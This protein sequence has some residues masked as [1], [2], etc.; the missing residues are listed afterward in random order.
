MDAQI[1][2][3]YENYPRPEEV[4]REAIGSGW[5]DPPSLAPITRSS[6]GREPYP[7]SPPQGSRR[8]LLA[9]V[10]GIGVVAVVGYGMFNSGASGGQS[11]GESGPDPWD[12]D[13]PGG[14]VLAIGGDVA[15]PE[16]WTAET[17]TDTEA[18]LTTGRNLILLSVFDVS[19][20]ADTAL[21][22]ALARSDVGFTGTLSKQ[23]QSVRPAYIRYAVSGTGKFKG[24][25]ARQIA[26]LLFAEDE[27]TALFIQ[28]VLTEDEDSTIGQQATQL[29]AD[30]RDS[31]PW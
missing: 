9:G 2:T 4:Q 21:R 14:D 25:K 7:P 29:V 15:V 18:L 5:Q 6:Q 28:Q 19:S 10:V 8:S 30:L 26:E 22:D 27:G 12:Y 20:D 31:W 16:G 3:G 17:D 23:R 11:G 1:P 24:A 13:E